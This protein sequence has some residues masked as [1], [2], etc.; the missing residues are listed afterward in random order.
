M[1]LYINFQRARGDRFLSLLSWLINKMT[2]SLSFLLQ[3]LEKGDI[4]IAVNDE[5]I[6]QQPFKLIAAK[7]KKIM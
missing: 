5:L 2:P 3:I 4:L 6:I 7:F 1:L